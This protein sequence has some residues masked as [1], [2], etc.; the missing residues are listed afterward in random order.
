MVVVV[1]VVMVV[2]VAVAVAAVQRASLSC[3]FHA[4]CG[5]VDDLRQ[6]VDAES[7]VE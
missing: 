7:V 5:D 3:H 2:A 4:L 1:V 6:L